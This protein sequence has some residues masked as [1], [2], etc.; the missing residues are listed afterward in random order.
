MYQQNLAQ[1]VN[2][3]EEVERLVKEKQVLQGIVQEQ[4]TLE[5]RLMKGL[6]I[7]SARTKE[8][9]A[10]INGGDLIN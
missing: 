9:E 1:K 2:H 5:K 10:K 4:A 3:V 8:L 6:E 7:S